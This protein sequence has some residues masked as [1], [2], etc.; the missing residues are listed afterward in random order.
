MKGIILAGGKGTR[1]FPITKG[2][3]KQLLPIYDKPMIYYPLSVLMLSKIREVLIISNP[4]YIDFYKNLLGDGSSLGMKIT[5]QVQER[6]R[7]LADAFIVGE[8]FI[9]N[10]SVCLILGDNIFYGQGFVP[11]LDAAGSVKDGAV[12]FG[13]YVKD[14]SEFG[15]VEFDSEGNVLSLEEKPN[16][17]K[18]NYAIPGLYFY[19]NSVINRA[20]SLKASARGEIEI[21]DLNKGYLNEQRLKVELLGRG[22]AWLDTG[23]YDGLANASDFVRTMQ[24]RTGLYIAC[25]EEIAYKNQWISKEALCKLGQ[26]Y[27]KTEYG[28]YILSIAKS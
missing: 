5:Y 20:K 21:T 10:D 16:Q 24:K 12:I 17:P 8:E 3:S 27:K 22:F 15:V 14:P 4:E 2:I 11:R 9:G 1:L 19:D 18:S 23:T 7:G 28:K 26:V 6:P 13:Y 25:L